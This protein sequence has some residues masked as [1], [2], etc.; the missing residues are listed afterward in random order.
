MVCVPKVVEAF[1][2]VHTVYLKGSV[3]NVD[4]QT[5]EEKQTDEH[6]YA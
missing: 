1:Y 4:P 5:L 2:L 3:G 6:C